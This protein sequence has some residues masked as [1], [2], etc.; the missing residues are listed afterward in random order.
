MIP[1]FCS[2][3]EYGCSELLDFLLFKNHLTYSGQLLHEFTL[4]PILQP[5]LYTFPTVLTTRILA[6]I[7]LILMTL[8]LSSALY[9]RETLHDSS[10]EG[11]KS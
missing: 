3:Y 1:L 7:P 5:A 9:C 2:S 10:T 4:K 8:I 11:L 6:I